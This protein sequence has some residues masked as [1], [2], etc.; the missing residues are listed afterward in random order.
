M[1]TKTHRVRGIF[2]TQ[3]TTLVS[4]VR[5]GQSE[6]QTSTCRWVWLVSQRSRVNFFASALQPSS[7]SKEPA[8]P[9]ISA[10]R[11]QLLGSSYLKGLWHGLFSILW[12]LG[13]VGYLLEF[14][15]FRVIF[16]TFD[17]SQLLGYLISGQMYIRR[18][19]GPLIII[20]SLQDGRKSI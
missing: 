19:N 2:D 1:T 18:A 15:E 7:T 17:L 9:W 16:T 10:R 20:S 14:L 12:G 11:T 5:N 8:D 13:L 6:E 4:I 3:S